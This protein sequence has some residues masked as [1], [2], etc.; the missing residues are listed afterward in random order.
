MSDLP[1]PTRAKKLPRD[2]T[3]HAVPDPLSDERAPTT[4]GA[5]FAEHKALVDARRAPL[6]RLGMDERHVKALAMPDA[7]ERPLAPAPG[8]QAPQTLVADE[9]E[10]LAPKPKR[11]PKNAPMAHDLEE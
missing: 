1:P 5:Y 8:V 6:A 7:T 10:T 2:A 4:V 11:L 3:P 9:P